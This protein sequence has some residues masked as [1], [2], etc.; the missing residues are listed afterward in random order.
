MS[1]PKVFEFA[2]ELGME[3]LALMDKIREWKLPIKSHMAS[4]DE[5]MTAEIRS[6]LEAAQ[7]SGKGKAKKKVTKKA[8]GAKKKVAKKKAASDT[9]SGAIKKVSL[10]KATSV[11]D[12][13]AKKTSKKKTK[14]VIRRK[15][16]ALEKNQDAAEAAAQAAARAEEEAAQLEAES[17]QRLDAEA[18]G[19]L[20]ALSGES[21]E[22]TAHSD[23]EGGTAQ[24]SK[25]EMGETGAGGRALGGEAE[26]GGAAAGATRPRGNI[27]GRMDL[28]R[29]APPAGRGGPGAGAAGGAAA[30]GAQGAGPGLAGRGGAV[31]PRSA[32]RNLRTGFFAA[33]SMDLGPVE[34]PFLEKKAKDDKFAVKKK[35]G[36]GGK[37]EPVQHFSATEFRKREVIFQPKKKRLQMGRDSK[38]TM[39]TVPKASKRVVKVYGS[40]KLSDLAQQMGLKV[41]EVMKKLMA[42]GVMANMNTDLDFDT[43]SLLVPDFGF[44]AQNLE[45]SVE[46]VI[47]ELAF[48]DLQAELQPR[49][50]VVTVMG[51]VDHGKTT[52][53]DSIRRTK[54]V[55]G[56]AGGITQHI[57]AYSVPLDSGQK[58]TFIDTPGHEAFTAMRARGANVTDVVIIVV[59]ADDGV[60]P[61][62]VEAINHAKAAGV[63]IV[64]AVNKID[65]QGANV[66]RIKQQ[67]AEHEL[68]PEDWGG[69][70]IFCEVSALKNQGITE[71]LEQVLVVAE[72]LEL[73]ANPK[74]SASGIVIE[75]RMEKGR[76][77]VATL[78]VREGS[79]EVGQDLVAGIV[80][81][82]VRSML[83]DRGEQVKVVGPGDP[84]EIMG[85]PETP[86]A[87]E[88][89]DVVKN[90]EAARE[91]AEKRKALKEADEVPSS[92]MSLDQIFAKMKSGDV[93]ELGLVLKADVAGSIEAIKG[94]LEKLATDEVK[95]KVIHSAVGGVSES[96]V[97]LASTAQALVVGF[98]VRPDGGA[99]RLAKE[100]NIE[101]KCYTIIYELVDELK[102]AMSGLLSPDV[103]EEAQGRAEVRETF[104]VPKM[105]T[106]AGCSVVD[107]KIS[108]NHLLRLVR[109]GRVVYE[110]K[111]GSLRRFKDDVKEVQSGYE[112]GIGI[113]NFNDIKVG[114]LIEA[115]VLEERARELS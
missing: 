104:V 25:A 13:P 27:V 33:P 88:R 7:D 71:L 72:I 51:H 58:V 94:M 37:E 55:S 76:G 52:L 111:V 49:P 4:L 100:K 63:P 83:N 80:P 78:L 10:K 23:S 101:I 30:S 16:G 35:P 15:G 46:E 89:F 97:L 59:A 47:E 86:S 81:G 14:A 105:G 41:P 21:L 61:Q 19:E 114:D 31:G 53:L 45:R 6:R 56:E 29:I 75:S 38:K 102:K 9:G 106:I 74:R 87:G 26:K 70:T 82:R 108:R 48:G 3:T 50:P 91:V 32:P 93:K 24:S 54:V 77:C 8:A 5:E 57:G 99:Q 1:Q 69:S 34:D 42:L 20:G 96:D 113:E 2:K 68:V 85:L 11:T 65:K 103:V 90:E 17:Q 22:G 60:M 98:N 62:T 112:C 115:Y 109:D 28:R 36:A 18:R 66:D 79:L 84:V 39:I 73:K 44:E 43:V 40:I 107:G 67:L 64:V 110:G 12:G 95:V 92:K